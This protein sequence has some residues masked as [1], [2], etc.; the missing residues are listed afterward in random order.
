MVA[1]WEAAGAVMSW[2]GP[3]VGNLCKGQFTPLSEGE[4]GT[5]SERYVARG[6]MRALALH[7]AATA[8][9]TGLVELRRPNWVNGAKAEAGGWRISA[10]GKGQG[11]FDAVVIAHNGKCANRL[12]AGMGVPAI[13]RQL[14]RLKLSANWVLMV[15]FEGRVPVPQGMQGAFV[16]DSE[17][18]SWAGN[19]T[20]KLFGLGDAAGA[21]FSFEC[22]TLISTQQFG[23]RHKVPQEAIPPDTAEEIADAML[24]AFYDALGGQLGGV[25]PDVAYRHVQLWGAALPLNTPGVPCIWDAVG[26]VGVVGDW[27]NG[28][29]S[30]QAAALSGQALARVIARQAA[31]VREEKGQSCGLH[32]DFSILKDEEIG[33]FPAAGQLECCPR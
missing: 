21:Q 25:L 11:V 28:G 8:E 18:L 30:M 29:G 3:V 17:V 2:S 24:G 10:K 5:G 9:G 13:H 4:G 26:R 32:A 7:L 27:V 12:S 15:A 16:R 19:N 14:R 33:Q 1:Q 23:K 6:G 31:G 22:W 20:A